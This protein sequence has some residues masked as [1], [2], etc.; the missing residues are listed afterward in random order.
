MG[1]TGSGTGKPIKQTAGREFQV[2]AKPAGAGCNLKCSYCY[3]I[4]NKN[5]PGHKG[6]V[7]MSDTILEQFIR[8][9]IEA[10]GGST[11]SFSWHGGEPLIAGL[12]FFRRVVK[13]QRKYAKEGIH[14]LNGIQTNGTLINSDWARF[15]ND[16][17]FFT[18]ISI[19]GPAGMHDTFRRTAN[20]TGSFKKVIRGFEILKRNNIPVEVLCVV[21]SVNVRFPDEVYS[22]FKSLGIKYI[23]FLP[24]VER[25][26]SLPRGVTEASVGSVDFGL[27]LARI[28]DEWKEHDIGN[29]KIQI[30]EEALRSAF[31]QEHTLCIFRERCGGVP[32]LEYDGNFYSCDH[33]VD[34]AHL[35]GNIM[36]G[37]VA[38]F[39]DSQRQQAFGNQKRAMLPSVCLECPVLNMCNGECP[40]NRI[41]RTS[42]GDKP[43]NYLCEGY[44]YFFSHCKPFADAV[45]A[46]WK[47][48]GGN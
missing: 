24:L 9:N 26:D 8:Q 38:G 6:P 20:N 47:I 46:A 41:L 19:D 30:I 32:V 10:S 37:S 27:F 18:G 42:D 21:N 23:T 45:S 39:L 14:V 48:S 36:D 44:K 28:F 31:N 29:V 16:E 35:I 7:I 2:F 17:S 25:D 5:H 33:Y 3:Y 13:L 43:L 34:N 40:K 11:A 1:K 22:F 4:N 15:F 12:E